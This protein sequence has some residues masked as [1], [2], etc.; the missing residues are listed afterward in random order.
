MEEVLVEVFQLPGYK[1]LP[2][3]GLQEAR[4]SLAF[5]KQEQDQDQEYEEEAQK[6]VQMVSQCWRRY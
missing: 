5:L 2:F 4:Q 6:G 3:A 1:R